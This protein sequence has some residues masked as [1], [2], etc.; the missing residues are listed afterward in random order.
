MPDQPSKSDFRFPDNLKRI[1][2]I[3]SSG[4]G[5]STLARELS[6]VLRV[7]HV[8]LDAI[9]HGP[10]WTETPDE[11]FRKKIVVAIQGE[12]WVVDGN[13]SVAR[14]VLWPRATTLIYLDYPVSVVMRR[15]IVRTLRRNIER[16]VL[17]NGNRENILDNLKI[18]SNESVIAYS[19]KNHWRLRRQF[20]QLFKRPEYAHIQKIRLHTPRAAEEWLEDLASQVVQHE[21]LS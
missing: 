11:V 9:R 10:N 18:L 1:V 21:G 2:V 14:A 6:R 17:W 3:G 15:L 12:R 19:F 8:E 5:K 7:P 20:T 13:Y 4:S 16:E